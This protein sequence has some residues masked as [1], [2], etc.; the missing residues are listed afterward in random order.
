MDRRH[1]SAWRR[2]FSMPFRAPPTQDITARQ[3]PFGGGV[4]ALTGTYQRQHFSRH[5]HEE[6]ALG[7]IEYGALRFRYRGSTLVAPAGSLS[8]AQP[9]IP[10]DGSPAVPEG[11][12]YSM[13]YLPAAALAA[14]L[15]D[16]AAAP[17]FRPGVIEDPGLAMILRH[18]HRLIMDPKASLLAQ[19]TRFLE[20]LNLWIR[21]H[22]DTSPP[23]PRIGPE[24]TAI[25]RALEILAARY[26]TN[27]S[28]EELAASV[29]LTPWHLARVMTKQTG[30]PPHAHLLEHR[31]RAA[32][33]RLAGNE[34]IADIA[35]AVGF[36]DQSHMTRAFRARFGLPPGNYRK[37]LQNTG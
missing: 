20:L 12:R 30:L 35:V 31:L 32:K 10:H 33:A 1:V 19:E 2:F 29:N 23:P 26:E 28:L 7:V 13:L 4:F 27:V 16:H 5:A 25:R 11:W 18:T 21:R 14:V 17:Y 8:L 37:I 15:P 34:R 9:D 24:P 22:A 36:A 6:Y 3:L